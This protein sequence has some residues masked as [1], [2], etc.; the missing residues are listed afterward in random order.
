MPLLLT[1]D[2]ENT[3]SFPVPSTRRAHC[4]ALG[5]C[6]IAASGTPAGGLGPL[7]K[8]SLRVLLPSRKLRPHQQA[9]FSR[10]PRADGEKELG[11]R[12]NSSLSSHFPF[13]ICKICFVFFAAWARSS[14][15]LPHHQTHICILHTARRQ[16]PNNK[17]RSVWPSPVTPS[18]GL[19]GGWQQGSSVDRPS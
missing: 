12:A 14:L 9:S 6:G 19:V 17:R 10:Q 2:R 16:A 4:G 11:T 15:K 13:Q 5:C 8:P 1:I 18:V 7:P 3:R